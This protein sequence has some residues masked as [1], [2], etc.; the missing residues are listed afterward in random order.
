MTAR[1]IFDLLLLG[2]IWGASFLFMRVA[3]PE[4]GPIPLIAVRV[5]I[6]AVLVFVVLAMRGG[7]GGLKRLTGPF[8]V[9]GAINTAL[10]FSL[11]AYS[12]LSVTAGFASVLNAAVPLFGSLVGYLWLGDKLSPSRVLG[13]SAGFAG[14]LI[15]VW[16]RIAFTEDSGGW[17]ILAGLSAALS[18]GFAANY[19]KKRLTGVDPLLIATGNLIAAAVLL[20]VP[21]LVSLP[22]TSPSRVSW[23]SAFVLGVVCTGVA[24]I[25]Y[26]KLI[27]RIGPVKAMTVTYLIPAFGVVWGA[28]I[29]RE[30]VTASM[31]VACG[32]ILLG[33]ALA[34]GTLNGPFR[35]G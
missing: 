10:P 3:A 32:A 7:L 29:L 4:F 18:Y 23:V 21:A 22:S 27:S 1:D 11:F 20:M 6:A 13:L 35:D 25:L 24:Y 34:T 14:V 2:A 15:L 17:A 19:T 12:L 16:G 31:L 33:T 30:T 28:V 9:L 8:L 5:G 26:F